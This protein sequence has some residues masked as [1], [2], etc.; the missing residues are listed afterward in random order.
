MTLVDRRVLVLDD[1]P[2]APGMSDWLY[3]MSLE[4]ITLPSPGP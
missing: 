4:R 2:G 3:N 1:V